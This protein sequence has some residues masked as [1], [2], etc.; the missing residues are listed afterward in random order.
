[1]GR[2][3]LYR[4]AFAY[5]DKLR[6]EVRRLRREIAG[7]ATDL[8][9]RD[10][11]LARDV[12]LGLRAVLAENCEHWTFM[13]PRGKP[14]AARCAECGKNPEEAGVLHERITLVYT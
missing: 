10:S 8:E 7:R 5:E 2:A 6:T 3:D 4:Q 11:T 13:A 12:A 9:Q 1:M 14:E